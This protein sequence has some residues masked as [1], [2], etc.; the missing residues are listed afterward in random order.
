MYAC[1][2]TSLRAVV[3]VLVPCSMLAS[4]V[5]PRAHGVVWGGVPPQGKGRTP[6]LLVAE[7]LPFIIIRPG[8]RIAMASRSAR[9]LFA[10]RAGAGGNLLSLTADTDAHEAF[11]RALASPFERT[12]YFRVAFPGAAGEARLYRMES[13][14]MAEGDAVGIVLRDETQSASPL[15]VNAAARVAEAAT[16]M[17]GPLAVLSG[18][19]ET[20]REP[21]VTLSPAALR[22][23]E[24]QVARLRDLSSGLRAQDTSSPLRLDSFEL[25]PAVQRA[26]DVHAA[27]MVETGSRLE[28]NYAET[29]LP[30]RGDESLLQQLVGELLASTL[31]EPSPRR[32]SLTAVRCGQQVV[33]DI[34]SDGPPLRS[35]ESRRQFEL[36][37]AAARVQQGELECGTATS[38]GTLYRL[39]FPA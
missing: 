18:W 24:R 8:G 3:S 23:M 38:Q 5:L 37:Q 33:I 1:F 13:A 22:A 7:G 25:A 11:R 16:S 15:Q 39:T 28:L 20:A 36:L 12:E 19:L 34:A 17:A 31:Y 27:R 35:V 9:R 30:L 6:S 29:P 26:A 14:P 4:L 21:G 2:L 10:L 32:L